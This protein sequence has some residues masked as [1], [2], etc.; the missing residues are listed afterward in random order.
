[1]S[2]QKTADSKWDEPTTVP[3]TYVDYGREQTG[4]R[5]W[6]VWAVVGLLVVVVGLVLFSHFRQSG[7]KAGGAGGGPGAAGGRPVQVVTAIARRGDMDLY[8]TG[9]G[10]VT[11]LNTVTIR[12]RVDG[13]LNRVAFSEG[14]VV[15]EGDLLVEIDPRPFEVQLT[16]A[17]GQMAKD[18][19]ELANAQA[20]LVRYQDLL[21]EN[22]I[23]RQQVDTQAAT[24]RQAEGAVKVDQGQI[25]SAKLNLTYA[26]ITAPL[27]GRIGL[28]LV[29]Q[30]NMVHANDQNGL[31]VITQLQPIAIV[32]TLPEDNV[33]QVM[34]EVNAGRTLEVDAFDHDLKNNLAKGTLGAV[35]SQIDPSTGTVKMK[36]VFPNEDYAL[37]P[38][39]FVNARLL[40]E[41]RRGVVI[42]PSAAVQRGT[43]S[44][45]YVVK[46]DAVELRNIVVGPTEGEETIIESG[47]EAGEVVVTDGVDKLQPGTKVTVAKV[48]PGAAPTTN[49]AAST[50]KMATT[51][52]ATVPAPST[53]SRQVP[54]EK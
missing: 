44:F 37:F 19:A 7:L 24:V 27:T 52:P 21:K 8:L 34:G 45:M 28:R 11:P 40:V 47:L 12:T 54:P 13:Q 43:Q 9:L 31:A 6:W 23:A 32:F 41:T 5:L 39:Q 26:R 20:D 16:Q 2:I 14:Q 25:D 36:A 4:H 48:S 30:G 35:D 49:K 18:Q 29:D 42:V 53:Q 22:S 1:M 3:E 46:D 38:N 10:T 50:R 51:L 15:H 33:R 17:Q